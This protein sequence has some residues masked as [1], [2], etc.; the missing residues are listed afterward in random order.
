MRVEPLILTLLLAAA[1]GQS[2]VTNP[3]TD[4]DADGSET[5]VCAEA[6][7][8]SRWWINVGSS[9]CNVFCMGSPGYPECA[10]SDCEQVSAERFDAGTVRT[11]VPMLHSSQ[12]RGFYLLGAAMTESYTVSEC[13]MQ[14]GS[15]PQQ[16][17]SCN[18]DTLAFSVGEF[19]AA[20]GEQAAALDTAASMNVMQDYTY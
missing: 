10:Q 19:M 13:R 17:F 9:N 6:C 12:H 7:Y 20:T 8:E 11:L 14:V 5:N 18:G 4:G 2:S 1:C 15:R 16:M 3:P